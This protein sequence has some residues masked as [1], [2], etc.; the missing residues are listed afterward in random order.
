MTFVEQAS[1]AQVSVVSYRSDISTKGWVCLG[2]SLWIIS[3]ASNQELVMLMKTSLLGLNTFQQG[4]CPN[5]PSFLKEGEV[6][7]SSSQLSSKER[8]L[9]EYMACSH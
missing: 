2:Y 6:Y 7:L 3:F 5:F 4:K 1:L 8:Q 9:E